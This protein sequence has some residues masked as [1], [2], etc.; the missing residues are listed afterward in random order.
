MGNWCL[1]NYDK[2][3][4]PNI[5]NKCHNAETNGL[6]VQSQLDRKGTYDQFANL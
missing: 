2:V 3:K 6:H 5:L 1:T 4:T